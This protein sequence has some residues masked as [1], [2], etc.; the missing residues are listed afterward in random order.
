MD[1][2]IKKIDLTG[3]LPDEAR[4]SRLGDTAGSI[5]TGA[6]GGPSGSGIAGS[7]SGG[8]VI[9]P[10]AGLDG[11][12]PT[13]INTAGG[14]HA[15]DVIGLADRYS[16]RGCDDYCDQET[17]TAEGQHTVSADHTVRADDQAA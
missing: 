8:T 2:K 14:G 1:D 6:P 16:G 10:S 3:A 11:P 9:N 4:E 7:S 5:G 12:N 13:N 17:A 15:G